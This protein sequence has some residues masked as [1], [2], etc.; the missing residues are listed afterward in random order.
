MRAAWALAFVGLALLGGPF[1][2][3]WYA[4]SSGGSAG[5]WV[6]AFLPC[7]VLTFYLASRIA[8]SAWREMA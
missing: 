3:I 7:A 8:R 5:I 1:A 2:A 4:T 6:L